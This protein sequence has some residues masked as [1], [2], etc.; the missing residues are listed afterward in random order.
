MVHFDP[1]GEVHPEPALTVVNRTNR[2]NDP[3]STDPIILYKQQFIS[4]ATTFFVVGSDDNNNYRVFHEIHINK[5]HRNEYR[6]TIFVTVVLI[7]IS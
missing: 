1:K 5:Y 3:T 2:M 7:V 4:A 6:T